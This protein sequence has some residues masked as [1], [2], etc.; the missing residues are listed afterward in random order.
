MFNSTLQIIIQA[1]DE[2]SQTLSTLSG[3]L[4]DMQPQFQAMAVAGTAAFAAIAGVAV[5][6]VK[7]ASA[8][9]DELNQLNA[10]LKSTGGVAGETAAKAIELSQALQ[11]T[12]TY[13]DDAVLST[14]NLLL[15][16][17]KIGSDIFPQVTQTTL[18]MAT[19]LGEDT[20]SA[21]IQLGKALQDPVLGITAL[22]RVG[23]NFSDDQ[24]EVIKQLVATGQSAQAQQIILKELN[25]EF[26]GSAAAATGSFGGQMSQLKNQMDD[27]KKEV[28][29]ALIPILESLVKT[30]EPILT[31]MI[32]WV[33]AHP[34]LTKNIILVVGAVTGLV[35]IV[36]TLGLLLPG[37]IVLFTALTGPIGI[38]IAIVL[39][40]WYTVQKLIDIFTLLRDHSS[41]VWAGLKIMF[42]EAIDA[43]VGFFQPLIDIID[44]IVDKIESI[45]TGIANVAKSV[46]SKI[47]SVFTGKKAQGGNVSGGST[48]LVGESGPELFTAP[49]GGS[50]LPNGALGSGG[51][52]SITV[53]VNGGNYLSQDAAFMFGNT[54]I[55]QLQRQM[56]GA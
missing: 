33:Q 9:Q 16:F 54:I 35:A 4:K 1:R 31:K 15:T 50:I 32:A 55:K 3:K 29:E 37:I 6:S 12:T 46:G 21:A 28:G 14:E 2:A 7:E 18:D 39:V 45:G 43:I 24:K 11:K 48:Y 47:A 56:R 52:S 51:G 44:S 38:I 34:Q 5:S 53:N 41:E 17:T 13:S 49:S 10:V 26:G 27:V 20:K 23:V 30:I 25:T 8:W 19:A 40:L 22:R 42:K 36:G